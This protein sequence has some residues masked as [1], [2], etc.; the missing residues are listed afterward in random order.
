MPTLT[1]IHRQQSLAVSGLGSKHHL[2]VGGL[3]VLATTL[4]NSPGHPGVLILQQ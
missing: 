4:V 2:V 1:E 3:R